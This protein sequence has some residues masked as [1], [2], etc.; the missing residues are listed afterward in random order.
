MNIFALSFAVMLALVLAE[1]WLIK[2][3]TAQPV[4]W[5]DVVFNLNSGHLLMWVLRGVEIAAYGF[6]LEHASVQWTSRWPMPAQWV[7][8]FIAWDLCFYWMH[9]MH[10]KVPLL[11]AVHR[12]HHQGE[13][14]NLSLGIRNGWYSSL[15]NFPFIAVLAI[16]GVPLDMFIAVSSLHYAVQLYNHNALVG[17]SGILDKFLVTPSNHRVHHG[18]D[19]RYIDR[20]FGGTLLLWD[21]LFGSWQPERDDIDMRFGVHGGM[22]S[23][24]PLWA[25]NPSLWRWLCKRQSQH[26]S[27]E[28]HWPATYIGSGGVMLFLIVIA[29][30]DGQANWPVFLSTGSL[31][32]LILSTIALGALSDGKRWGAIAWVALCLVLPALFLWASN[33]LSAWLCVPLVLLLAHGLR[34]A[35]HLKRNIPDNQTPPAKTTP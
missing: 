13:H 12:I 27:P 24:N 15:T 22:P 31:L 33:F 32:A 23:Q 5:I 34:G 9:R 14:F 17:R 6:T 19:P 16:L 11:W 26:R 3:R 7:F 4:P 25:N 35:W 8:A 30:I 21:R 28:L 2:R 29:H 20:N 18:M 1:Q 10:H